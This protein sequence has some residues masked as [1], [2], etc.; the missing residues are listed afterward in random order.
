MKSSLSIAV[1]L[2]VAALATP[3]LASP[4]ACDGSEFKAFRTEF[5]DAANA[6][7]KSRLAKLIVFPVETAFTTSSGDI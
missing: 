7:D 2:T 1:L 4:P 5:T 6:N 3:A